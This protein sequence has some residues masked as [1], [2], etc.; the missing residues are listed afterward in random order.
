M[1]R[2]VQV[3]ALTPAL[4]RLDYSTP[5]AA[6]AALA[7]LIT[8]APP[9]A[10]P[11]VAAAGAA[12]PAGWQQA[13]WPQ[14]ADPDIARNGHH[15]SLPASGSR[16]PA[17]AALTGP[18]GPAGPGGLPG[19]ARPPWCQRPPPAGPE[20][21]APAGGGP[22]PGLWDALTW[23]ARREGFAAV[24]TDCGPGLGATDWAS[25]RITIAPDL[26]VSEAAVALVH[27]LAHVLAHGCL[28]IVPGAGTAGCRGIRQVEADSA[29]GRVPAGG[30]ISHVLQDAE[31]FYLASPARS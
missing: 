5:D 25:H 13:G 27:E 11:P 22:P 1:L 4:A 31:R 14:A 17:P 20:P 16:P 21:A 6:L 9:P 26:T 29:A 7:S 3:L 10:P 2:Q 23:L 12:G 15:P 18:G 19:G 8:P 28:A 24:R 30:G